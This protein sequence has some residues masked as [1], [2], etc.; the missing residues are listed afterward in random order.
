[1]A[2]AERCVIG[3]PERYLVRFY[4]DPIQALLASRLLTT[5]DAVTIARFFAD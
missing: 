3:Y 2:C 1:M 4:A 5:V